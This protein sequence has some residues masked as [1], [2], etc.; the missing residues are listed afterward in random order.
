MLIT[1]LFDEGVHMRSTPLFG[2]LL[3]LTSLSS[4]ADKNLDGTWIIES[5]IRDGKALENLKGATRENKGESY[6]ITPIKGEA[7]SGKVKVDPEKKTIDIMPDGGTYKGKTLLGIYQVSG[8]T[9]KICYAE[10]GKDRPTEFAAPAGSG[11]T[12]ATHKKK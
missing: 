12:L 10:P 4:A 7:F 11:H 8:D 5:A 6:T 1:S 2:I 9:L 3:I